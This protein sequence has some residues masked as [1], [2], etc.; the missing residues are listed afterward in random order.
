MTGGQLLVDCLMAQGVRDIFGMPGDHLAYVYDG[1]YHRR[2][3]IRHVLVRNEQNASL[4]AVGCARSTGEVG[5]CLT[6]PGPGASN[7]V[8]GMV[9]ASVG[10]DP[11]LLITGQIETKWADVDK[12]RVFHGLDRQALF[13]P[14]AK[15]QGCAT[16]PDSVP[17]LVNEAFEHLRTGR[18]GPVVVEIPKD[19][20]EGE[21]DARPSDRVDPRPA[22]PDTGA[23]QE[24]VEIVATSE[25][26][27][28]VAGECVLYERAFDDL[29][30]L[31]RTIGAP[32]LATHG[33]KGAISE[34]SKWF[35]ADLRDAE[36][37]ALLEQSDCCIVVG[38][39]LGQTETHN[40]QLPIPSPRI[41]L[42]ADPSELD[43]PYS[44]DVRLIGSVKLS[45]AAL[46]RSLTPR[47]DEPLWFDAAGRD[48]KETGSPLLAGIRDV[49]DED[50]ILVAGITMEGYRARREFKVTRPHTFMFSGTYVTLGF[51][52]PAALG[53]KAGN[54]DRQVVALCGDG[55]FMFAC[56]ELMTAIQ[57]DLPITIVVVNDYCLTSIKGGQK[58]RFDGRYIAVDLENPDFVQLAESFGVWARRI[59]ESDDIR[60]VL[61]QALSTGQASL[62]EVTKG[63]VQ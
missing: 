38:A 17:D 44:F 60:P 52:V 45:M 32:V 42:D 18:P 58:R 43:G 12:R 53:A 54:P 36:G 23:A 15:W 35:G 62:I 14:V 10:S 47:P 3:A 40:W 16:D 2:D 61:T 41:G 28:I 11:V 1:L 34:D 8:T 24:A 5:V 63:G 21:T 55:G 9:E 59:D 31:A 19:V 26:P 50:G 25:R 4:M 22:D 13:D 20:L 49:L 30:C 7:A 56:Q 27:T 46:T 37:R 57:F 29:E 51:G 33:G 39:R 6:I 48:S